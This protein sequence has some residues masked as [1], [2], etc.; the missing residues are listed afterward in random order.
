M[1][2]L[3]KWCI[4]ET[5]FT[6]PLLANNV[7]AAKVFWQCCCIPPAFLSLVSPS[8]NC[9]TLRRLPQFKSHR[10]PAWSNDNRDRPPLSY[11][12]TALNL[13]M[14]PKSDSRWDACTFQ[15]CQDAGQEFITKLWGQQAMLQDS[16][17]PSMQHVDASK[18]PTTM[19]NKISR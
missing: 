6:T 11:M 12:Q 2:Q 17:S 10:A 16:M 8:I 9:P 7:M 4:S 1:R 18:A 5:Q 15:G 14:L 3:Q 19:N 13:C